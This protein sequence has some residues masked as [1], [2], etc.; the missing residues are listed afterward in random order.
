VQHGVFGPSLQVGERDSFGEHR[1]ALDL[2]GHRRA[3]DAGTDNR[4]VRDELRQLS[5]PVQ[6]RHGGPVRYRA[7]QAFW[8]MSDRSG[9]DTVL[10]CRFIW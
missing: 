6:G 10:A 2:R 9:E 4:A 3:T 7:I 5:I 8:D 1:H